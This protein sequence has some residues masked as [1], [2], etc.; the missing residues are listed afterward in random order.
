MMGS[1]TTATTGGS[2]T[3]DSGYTEMAVARQC[4]REGCNVQP[5]YGIA[6]KKVRL[7]PYTL[8]ELRLS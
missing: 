8:C 7:M 3:R 4:E 1:A 6:W 5:S 2:A